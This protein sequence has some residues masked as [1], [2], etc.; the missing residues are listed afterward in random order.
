MTIWAA[1]KQ[2]TRRDTSIIQE[3]LRSTEGNQETRKKK[4]MWKKFYLQQQSSRF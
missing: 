4:K 2:Q 3:F 1:S